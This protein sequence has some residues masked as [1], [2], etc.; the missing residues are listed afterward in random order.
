M[1][2]KLGDRWLDACDLRDRLKVESDA[3]RTADAP[4]F[5]A[6]N[7]RYYE[8]AILARKLGDEFETRVDAALEAEALTCWRPREHEQRK[9]P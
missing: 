9:R 3:A 2:K 4:G 1:S 5:D 6:I 8:A 7:D